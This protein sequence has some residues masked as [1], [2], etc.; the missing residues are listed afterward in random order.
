MKALRI[1]TEPENPITELEVATLEDYQA[2]VG[3]WIEPVDIPELGI[4]IYV[5]EEGLVLGLPFNSGATFLWWYYVPEA[6][7][8]AMLVGPAVIVG[9]PDANGDSTS[10]P[11]D[12]AK[13]L[14]QSGEWRI[15]MH[16]KGVDDWYRKEAPHTDYFEAIVWALVVLERS[17]EV[18]DARVIPVGSEIQYRPAQ[19]DES[20][21]AA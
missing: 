21:P 17:P 10:I 14:T 9:L 15:E 19:G 16:A 3:G 6:R 20:P 2:V 13:L 8:K 11:A 1:P 5:H 4:T 12:T 18:D 7:Q